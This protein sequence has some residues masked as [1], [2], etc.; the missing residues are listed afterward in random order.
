MAKSHSA[1]QLEAH[2]SIFDCAIAQARAGDDVTER[3]P[4]TGEKIEVRFV[5]REIILSTPNRPAFYRVKLS[6]KA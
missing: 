2:F 1:S 4:E 3:H 6:G 5:G